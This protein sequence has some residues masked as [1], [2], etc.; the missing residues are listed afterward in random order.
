MALEN[1]EDAKPEYEEIS[2]QSG[3][4]K[5]LIEQLQHLQYLL[6]THVHRISKGEVLA[7]LEVVEL[8]RKELFEP[9]EFSEDCFQRSSVDLMKWDVPL[10][11]R[12]NTEFA[13]VP[14]LS[15]AVMHLKYHDEKRRANYNADLASG[16]AEIAKKYKYDSVAGRAVHSVSMRW[17]EHLYD[18]VYTFVM[19]DARYDGKIHI[20]LTSKQCN[21]LLEK[22]FDTLRALALASRAD[23]LRINGIGV[24]TLSKILKWFSNEK[25][26]CFSAFEF[27]F[28]GD[29]NRQVL[30]YLWELPK[31][32]LG[33]Q[34]RRFE[35]VEGDGHYNPVTEGHRF[36]SS[37]F[38]VREIMNPQP[39]E[40]IRDVLEEML[41]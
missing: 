37:E 28:S 39:P 4:I 13:E 34:D 41:L 5:G 11:P 19:N 15:Y 8:I 9:Y 26:F 21:V 20:P 2:V 30:N 32:M 12:R 17:A 1:V 18:A 14:A 23:I 6:E 33:Q 36:R 29:Q 25:L 38:W 35:L 27:G 22:N 40:P 31:G 10:E 3:Y 24:G 7:I 16:L